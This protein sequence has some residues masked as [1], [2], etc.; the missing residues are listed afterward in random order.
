MTQVQFCQYNEGSAPEDYLGTFY[1]AMKM[2]TKNDFFTTDS[3]T[4]PEGNIVVDSNGDVVE[5]ELI[6]CESVSIPDD[7]CVRGVEVFTNDDGKVTG[8]T[9]TA[10]DESTV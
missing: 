7:T 8:L 5:E 4:L 2:Q 3:G 10:S 1:P 6:T 9:L